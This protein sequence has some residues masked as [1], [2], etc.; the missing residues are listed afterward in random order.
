MT[1]KITTDRSALEL[2]PVC[3]A[4]S[5]TETL[6]IDRFAYGDDKVELTVEVP[7]LTC[8]S[9]HF[10]FTDHRA[11]V[12]R[13]EA[14]CKH[15]ELLSPREIHQV[16]SNL[17]MTRRQFADAFGIPRASMDRWETGKLLQN[18]SLDTLL[19]ALQNRN[20]ALRLDR[21]SRRTSAVSGTV[22]QFRT[23]ERSAE[24][25]AE[26]QSREARFHLRAAG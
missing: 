25:L 4:S 7:I 22:I 6:S 2:C 17:G 24:R 5:P 14:I 20:T 11:E 8:P 1:R 13:H 10:E 21:R 18:R 19:R 15:E 23:L 3:N 12:L 26:A 16:R 9:C